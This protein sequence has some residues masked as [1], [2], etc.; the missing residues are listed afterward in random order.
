MQ[1]DF[2]FSVRRKLRLCQIEEIMKQSLIINPPPS[3]SYYL[4]K[5]EDG[6]LDGYRTEFG[7]VVFEDSFKAWVKRLEQ[8]AA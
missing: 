2:G 3:R 7:W 8:K 4:K 1:Y 5:L 6:T